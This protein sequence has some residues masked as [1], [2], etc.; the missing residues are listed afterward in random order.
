MTQKTPTPC[1]SCKFCD[2]RGLPLLLVRDAVAPHGA[3]APL[4]NDLPIELGA[5]A[6]HYTKRL[7]RSGYV[8]LYD[9]ARKRWESY[10]VTPDGY[11]FMF[12]QVNDAIP[13]G[14]PT[15]FTCT[16]G[17]RRAI[18]SCIMISDPK[19]A[20]KVWIGFSDVLW[21]AKVRKANGD[22][23]YRKRHMVEIDVR[24][25]LS[26]SAK[27]PTRPM[28]QLT[29]IVAEYAMDV[30]RGK[31]A[32]GWSAA[33]FQDRQPN[34]ERL[35]KECD[36]AYPGKARIIPVPD[37]V[38]IVQDLALLMKHNAET[39]VARPEYARNLAANAAISEIET[40]VRKQAQYDEINAAD[41]LA[42]EHANEHR[43]LWVSESARQ[44]TEK[45]R[46]IT[47]LQ[48]NRE[49]DRIWQ[50]YA[51]KFD[52]PARKAW[53]ASFEAALVAYDKKAILPL[54]RSH[55]SWMK[56]AHLANY[57]QCNYDD[58]N[59]NSGLA[60]TFVM[61][62]CV[63]STQDKASCSKLYEEW[64]A[65][66][67]KD[68]NNL[69][70][71]AMIYNQTPIGDVVEKAITVSIDLRQIP[72]DTVFA[73]YTNS[74]EKVQSGAVDTAAQFIAQFG[75]PLSKMVGK[76]M[77]GSRGFRSAVMALGLIAGHPV[78]VFEIVGTRKEFR[79]YVTKQL[80]QAAGRPLS[81]KQLRKAVDME[82]RRQGIHGL[83]VDGSTRHKFVVLGDKAVISTMPAGLGENQR[84]AWLTSSIKTIA[85]V[86][87][88][89]LERWRTV[90]SSKLG[91][92]LIA[93][94]FQYASLTKLV[95]DQDK[96][97]INESEDARLR[98][99]A[100]IVTL[101][102][103]TSEIIGNLLA[104]RAALGLRIGQ[105][106][107]TTSGKALVVV[108]S[109]FGFLTGLVVAG[110]DLYKAYKESTE[111]ADGL[112]VA[113]YLGSAVTGAALSIVLVKMAFFGAIAI[114]LLGLLIILLVGIGIFIEF[115]KD[116]PVQDWLER[117]PWGVLKNQR[118]P[119]IATEQSQLTQALK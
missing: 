95:A 61:T 115:I 38:G 47:A 14:L 79:A 29:A 74:V 100:G 7:L 59:I 99:Y 112:L 105:G 62:R 91:F 8:Y 42:D 1:T 48:A 76:V 113:S 60:Y 108:G 98:M 33:D 20:T 101:A 77:D 118:Y 70:L 34:A 51:K 6:A 96:A 94:I 65:G 3:G 2:K 93:G 97:L 81:K 44:R 13:L 37:P 82:L 89:N 103:T 52:D 53:M 110:F 4:A 104:K 22:A 102:A 26:G 36:T 45:L 106:I 16:D 90:V 86:D 78:V 46:Q 10:H 32:F 117:C 84:I 114:P 24:A 9:E 80:I 50:K 72:W 5:S 69:L 31:K 40:A 21:T 87:E 17:G 41:N 15:A 67:M 75:G 39:F 30:A 107:I 49:S 56:S 18:A 28:A 66:S 43:A 54:A 58:G 111:D 88:M 27:A 35:M 109:A 55:V 64:L 11:L 57:F 116:N 63:A 73:V 23:A 68:N 85:Q 19:R 92:G 71:R 119:D 25:I 83:P 12:S